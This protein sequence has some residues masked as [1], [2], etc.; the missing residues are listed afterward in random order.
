ML[1]HIAKD[2]LLRATASSR[3]AWSVTEVLS[4][5][6]AENEIYQQHPTLPTDGGALRRLQQPSAHH[7]STGVH[8]LFSRRDPD[9]AVVSRSGAAA[10]V[11]VAGRHVEGTVRTHGRRPQT[12]ELTVEEYPLFSHRRELLR[13]VG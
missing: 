12:P 7:H 5:T 10:A 13:G 4:Q 1:A 3:D 2:R 6:H 9:Y 11:P 8:A